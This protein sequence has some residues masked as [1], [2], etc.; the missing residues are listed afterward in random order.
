MIQRQLAIW[1]SLSCMYWN[2]THDIP[3]RQDM[4]TLTIQ[5]NNCVLSC[6][7]L[8]FVQCM[9]LLMCWHFV[10]LYVPRLVVR[11]NKNLESWIFPTQ[12]RILCSSGALFWANMCVLAII[13]GGTTICILFNTARMAVSFCIII[14]Y[15]YN[16]NIISIWIMHCFRDHLFTISV[17][18]D[19]SPDCRH[20]PLI[21]GHNLVESGRNCRSWCIIHCHFSLPLVPTNLFQSSLFK[22]LNVVIY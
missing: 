19:L 18:F 11:V 6:K 2:Y 17:M 5:H 9:M 4:S 8:Y 12:G 3:C 16:N 15:L 1:Q 7:Y 14:L 10:I 20:F 22:S 13:V 21:V